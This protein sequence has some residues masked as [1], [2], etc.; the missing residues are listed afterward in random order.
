[1]PCSLCRLLERW[2]S[3]CGY[4]IHLPRYKGWVWWHMPRRLPWH[5]LCIVGAL[6]VS[7]LQT[8][9]FQNS[10]QCAFV[11]CY[12]LDWAPLTG[13]VR[14]AVIGGVSFLVVAKSL[15]RVIVGQVR[16]FLEWRFARKLVGKYD[17]YV[18]RRIWCLARLSFV[19]VKNLYIY[20]LLLCRTIHS[21][22]LHQSGF[23]LCNQTCTRA[24]TMFTTWLVTSSLC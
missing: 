22:Y 10:F 18:G 19:R 7:A 14:I 6:R 8:L 16:K 23:R 12:I 21:I 17:G 20:C 24:S 13:V 5:P 4:Q 3:W 2:L 11:V 9:V 15:A 1:M